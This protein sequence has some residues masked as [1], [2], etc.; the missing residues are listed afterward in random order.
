MQVEGVYTVQNLGRYRI[1]SVQADGSQV[2]SNKL[3]YLVLDDG[4]EVRLGARPD[5]EL[6][7]E[8]Q[9]VVAEGSEVADWPSAQDPRG[10]QVNAKPTLLQVTSVKPLR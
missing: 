5:A 9:R 6:G 4:S 8:G 7:L 3:A 1:I 10:A 2:Q